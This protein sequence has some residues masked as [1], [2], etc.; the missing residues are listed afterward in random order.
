MP[1]L[2]GGSRGGG[3]HGGG[4]GRGFRGGGGYGGGF[5][6]GPHRHF[7]FGPRFGF[8]GF[9]G[10]LLGIIMLPAMLVLF[11]IVILFT[12]VIG[13]F[14]AISGGGMTD[15]NEKEFQDYAFAQYDAVY[16]DVDAY[17]DNILIVFLSNEDADE[18]YYIAVV[19]NHIKTDVTDMFGA[20]RTALGAALER[21]INVN[22]Y[23]YTLHTNL[24]G[25]IEDLGDSVTSLRTTY[26]FTGTCKDDPHTSKSVLVN[27][28]EMNISEETVNDALA[29]FTERTGISMSIV[30]DDMDEVLGVDYTQMIIGII[31][32]VV[33]VG[34]ALLYF[35]Y[36]MSRRKRGEQ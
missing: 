17:E 11:A 1:G 2:G 13:A 14:S 30:V 33:L 22:G 26:Y 12:M 19:G 4:G 18:Y 25:A 8:F 28:T 35:G 7:H 9:G 34:G 16:G 21:N 27:R 3:G 6:G 24:R 20:E 36:G 31:I 5:H 15:Y 32:I 10:G 23:W 29:E